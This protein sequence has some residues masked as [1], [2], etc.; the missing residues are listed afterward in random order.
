LTPQGIAGRVGFVARALD[1]RP[2][3]G[4]RAVMRLASAGCE[5]GK[6]ALSE[7]DAAWHMAAAM[8]RPG[9]A[10]TGL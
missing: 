6:Q 8:L 10:S 9:Q 4:S 7:T 1:Q 2:F 5:G 3:Q